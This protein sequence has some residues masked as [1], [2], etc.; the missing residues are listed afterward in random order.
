MKIS[1]DNTGNQITQISGDKYNIYL[2][3]FKISRDTLYFHCIVIY[4]LL[5]QF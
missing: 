4:K 5:I 3:L 1:W 2:G